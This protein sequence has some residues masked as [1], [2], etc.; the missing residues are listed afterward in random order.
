MILL[1]TVSLLP[2][3]LFGG[4]TPHR[5]QTGSNQ[6]P[7]KLYPAA[8][9]IIY[10]PT[11]SNEQLDCMWDF[12]CEG[13]VPLFH[14]TTQGAL[15]RTGGWGQFAD[16]EKKGRVTMAFELFTSS[17]ASDGNQPWSRTAYRD[18][19]GR[20]VTQYYSFKKHPSSL[21]HVPPGGCLQATEPGSSSDDQ[22]LTVIACWSRD[23]EVE[24]IAMYAHHSAKAQRT[25]LSDL[26]LQVN[27]AM[28]VGVN[29]A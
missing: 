15:H 22:D 14:S 11:L 2:F 5:A 10:H 12:Y 25:A 29:P 21:L 3:A 16:I 13:G 1:V 20:L 27:A 6:I 26:A 8:A 17:Y 28:S 4:L 7:A 9:Q 19:R 24:A 23:V 18:L